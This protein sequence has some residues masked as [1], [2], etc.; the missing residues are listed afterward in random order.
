MFDVCKHAKVMQRAATFV[1]DASAFFFSPPV[2]LASALNQYLAAVSV[3]DGLLTT[4]LQLLLFAI[5]R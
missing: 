3:E 4:N 2:D 5:E 1:K